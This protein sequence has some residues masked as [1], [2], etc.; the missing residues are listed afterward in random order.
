MSLVRSKATCVLGA[1]MIT[2]AACASTGNAVPGGA[3]PY[4]CVATQ[5]AVPSSRKP[6]KVMPLEELR[7]GS[8]GRTDKPTIGTTSYCGPMPVPKDAYL[9]T[10]ASITKYL[11]VG[12]N[13]LD[14]LMLQILDNFKGALASGNLTAAL[15]MMTPGAKRRLGPALQALLPFMS[16]IVSQWSSARRIDADEDH[17]D[18]AITRY[19]DEVKK[20]YIMSFIQDEDGTWLIDSM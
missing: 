18:F 6:A 14:A 17:V 16:E 15:Q 4:H 9:G 8:Y 3:T 7:Y 1:L 20:I 19:T 2:M 11:I 13:E 12:V 10:V 5:V